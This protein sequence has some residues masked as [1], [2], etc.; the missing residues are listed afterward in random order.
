M[1]NRIV[2]CLL[3]C[4]FFT[5]SASAHVLNKNNTFSD[6]RLSEYANDIVL[7][8]S[9]GIVSDLDE[10]LEYQPQKTLTA[11]DLAAW[12]AKYHGIDAGTS[13]QLAQA[14][15][16]QN[17]VS[18]MDGEATYQ[19]VNEAFFQNQLDIHNPTE[20]LTRD[21]FAA[22]VAKHVHTDMGG[23][24]L[25]QMSGYTEGP[26]GKV[27]AVERVQKLT[28]TD[29]K[30]NVYMLTI[31]G[32]VYEMGMHPRAI[33]DSADPAVWVGQTISESY[34]GPN[35]EGDYAG[36]LTQEKVESEN[37]EH[38]ASVA[39]QLVVVGEEP[40]TQKQ[41]ENDATI[42]EAEEENQQIEQAL[43]GVKQQETTELEGQDDGYL[44]LIVIVIIIGVFIM[45]IMKFFR[46]KSKKQH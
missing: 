13:A 38:V 26:T 29:S 23:Q 8:S 33:A 11:Q 41:Q 6:L 44:K 10:S 3:L 16:E 40:Y 7:L 37:G 9:L 28:E 43:A 25:L 30:A 17:L 42:D 14:A 32:E 35:A 31:D 36:K 12:A 1:K 18:T 19:L 20:T 24:T 45:G 34:F 27:E 39:L 2:L 4:F 5:A 21:E 46:S 15:L 22:F